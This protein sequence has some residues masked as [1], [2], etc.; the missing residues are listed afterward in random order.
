VSD[1]EPQADAPPSSTL[2][3]SRPV[4]RAV[5]P[6]GIFAVVAVLV[7]RTFAPSTLGVIAGANKLVDVVVKLGAIVSQVF[8]V[9]AM[10]AAVLSIFA[11]ARSRLPLA[12]RLGAIALGG[13]AVLPTVWAVHQ[14]VPELSAALLGASAALVALLSAPTARHAPFAR[15][16]SA[17]VTLVAMG[18]LLRLGAVALALRGAF[19]Q[20]ALVRVLATAGFLADAAAVAAAIGAIAARNRR[21]TSPGSIAVLGLAL[22]TTRPALNGAAGS[23]HPADVFFWN[24][25]KILTTRPV[26]AIPLGFQIFVAF[27]APLVAVWS[28]ASRDA[29]APIA[30][31]VALALCA[32]GAVEM[33]PSALMLIVAGLGLALTAHDGRSLWASLATM[34]PRAAPN[35]RAPSSPDGPAGTAPS[36][37]RR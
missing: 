16:A 21:L 15:A 8:A 24:A 7:G 5:F 20:A 26:P 19:Q 29:V 36:D 34:G 11:A 6:L 10:M 33:P 25:A 12:A 28:L 3:L 2:A 9:A 17:V 30:G 32:H 18:G 31:A 27:L 37:E 23:L 35:P 1:Q 4:S 22:V 13:F 14:P